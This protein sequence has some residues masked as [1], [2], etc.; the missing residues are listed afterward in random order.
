M[1]RG[2]IIYCTIDNGSLVQIQSFV[3]GPNPTRDYEFGIKDPDH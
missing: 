3:P 2:A 1:L